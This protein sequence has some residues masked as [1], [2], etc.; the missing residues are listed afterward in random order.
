[1]ECIHRHVSQS[2]QPIAGRS[3]HRQRNLL[4]IVH[5]ADK[6]IA[7]TALLQL[8]H[9]RGTIWRPSKLVVGVVGVLKVK[10]TQASHSKGVGAEGEATKTAGGG[11]W[12]K[13]LRIGL[14][15]VS[16]VAW[17]D[18]EDGGRGHGRRSDRIM[19]FMFM[20]FCDHVHGC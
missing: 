6:V 16:C 13:K 7:A 4:A 11:T 20:C 3:E 14:I 10:R 1:M 8:E 12:P 18:G 15:V 2:V 5:N 9:E 19:V 17:M